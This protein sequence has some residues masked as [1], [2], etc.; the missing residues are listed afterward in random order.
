MSN[1]Y[2]NCAACGTAAFESDA[3]CVLCGE[4]FDMP[5]TLPSETNGQG[6]SAARQETK[7]SRNAQRI[8][9]KSDV[10]LVQNRH[11]AHKQYANPKKRIR[12]TTLAFVIVVFAVALVGGVFTIGQGGGILSLFSATQ[13]PAPVNTIALPSF[14][15]PVTPL[16]SAP[17]GYIPITTKEQLI[18]VND[19][20]TAK[21][22]LMNDIDLAGGPSDSWVPIGAIKSRFYSSLTEYGS[23]VGVFD[24]NG[25]T[26]SGLYVSMPELTQTQ[27]AAAGLFSTVMDAE[28]KNLAVSGHIE[29]GNMPGMYTY[30][31]GIA[32][33]NLALQEQSSIINCMFSGSIKGAHY[34][35]GIVGLNTAFGENTQALISGCKNTGTISGK[36]AG[37]IV[38][39]QESNAMNSVVAVRHSANFGG[40]SA[41]TSLVN[42][43]GGIVG[44][45]QSVSM[46][47][48]TEV[49][50]CYNMGA[51]AGNDSIGGIAGA[52]I[53]ANGSRSFVS[54]S[55]NRGS[56]TG[57]NQGG[58]ILAYSN[59]QEGNGDI[60]INQCYNTGLIK[61][62]S[63]KGCA[64]I[65]PMGSAQEEQAA[66]VTGC[67]Y[68]SA[69]GC[70]DKRAEQKL[71][72]EILA[73]LIQPEG[74]VF[75]AE[76]GSNLP[77]IKSE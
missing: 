55:Y 14:A 47:A 57:K 26:I 24:G 59:I 28:I 40:I 43:V 77:V 74:T 44:C 42:R 71:D 13:T 20:L 73:L 4:K 36:M 66:I 15:Q 32:G 49:F 37:G 12:P 53:V 50:A 18:A 16:S 61:V 58:G 62:K 33:A 6:M 29:L 9:V 64:A 68:T 48:S 52:A 75:E 67:F 1:G 60:T 23:F 72:E 63:S 8:S 2:K 38:G 5:E 54:S 65:A 21:Y 34:T 19:D 45:T 25:Y 70:K 30:A 27:V 56:V 39:H 46:N 69:S 41:P 31:G 76:T 22:I 35:G 51:I 7:V 3:Y 10:D 17:E 11:A